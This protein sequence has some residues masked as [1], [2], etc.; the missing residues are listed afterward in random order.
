MVMAP[1]AR[2]PHPGLAAMLAAILVATLPGCGLKSILG[3]GTGNIS[4][5]NQ[6]GKGPDTVRL[7]SIQPFLTSHCDYHIRGGDTSLSC[8]DRYSFQ[9]SPADTTVVLPYFFRDSLRLSRDSIPVTG[10]EPRL[11]G[12][13]EVYCRVL[14]ELTLSRTVPVARTR[15]LVRRGSGPERAWDVEYA[16]DTLKVPELRVDA[17]PFS[18][19]IHLAPK[20]GTSLE[21]LRIGSDRV[22]PDTVTGSTYFPVPFLDLPQLSRPISAAAWENQE[23]DLCAEVKGIQSLRVGDR[24]TRADSRVCWRFEGEARAA[25]RAHACKSCGDCPPESPGPNSMKQ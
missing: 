11:E 19:A 15:L 6:A 8:L 3:P 22:G 13:H 21:R 18:L 23:Y 16:F 10:L 1:P 2:F 12:Y 14:W 20:P 7:D 9:A 24:E 25:L 17:D 5:C 4:D